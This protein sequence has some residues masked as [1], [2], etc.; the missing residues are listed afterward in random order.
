[1]LAPL[2]EI[3]KD[4]RDS[5]RQ[6]VSILDNLLRLFIPLGSGWLT[7]GHQTTTPKKQYQKMDFEGS[8]LPRTS[9]TVPILRRA[10]VSGILPLMACC[11]SPSRLAPRMMTST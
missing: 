3:R 7:L 6:A 5:S 10:M 9:T 11:N 2:I 1:M 4:I 8:T